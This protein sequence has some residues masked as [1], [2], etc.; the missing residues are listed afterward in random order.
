[1]TIIIAPGDKNHISSFALSFPTTFVTSTLHDN[2]TVV[3]KTLNQKTFFMGNNKKP[4]NNSRRKFFSLIL[5][6]S[7]T[8]SKPEMV[9]MLT[10]EGKLVEVEKAIFEEA[11]KKKKATNK[12]IYDWMK[13]PSK[14][15]S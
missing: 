7:E 9:K 1:M 5:S 3:L 11:A 6:P 12:E 15:K 2:D 8:S 13:N 4:D 14:D 10:P